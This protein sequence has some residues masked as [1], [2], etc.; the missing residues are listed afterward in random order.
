MKNDRHIGTRTHTS[1]R[2]GIFL[3]ASLIVCR[4]IVY[5]YVR[6]KG[7]IIV[8]EAKVSLMKHT[9]VLRLELIG[10]TMAVK[11][12]NIITKTLTG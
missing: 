1:N 6:E 7:K 8:S 5:I 12:L 11:T 3:D 2:A 10:A 4:V 9:S